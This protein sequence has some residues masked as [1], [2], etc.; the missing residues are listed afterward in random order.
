[1]EYLQG[2][3]EAAYNRPFDNENDEVEVRSIINTEF[4]NRIT[5]NL[6]YI[7]IARAKIIEY[8][9]KNDIILIN[10]AKR[11]LK[12]EDFVE[13]V[14][15]EVEL[16]GT[17]TF[18][19][20][21]EP[22]YSGSLKYYAKT[23]VLRVVNIFQDKSIAYYSYDHPTLRFLNLSANVEFIVDDNEIDESDD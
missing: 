6:D 19:N 23:E 1:M 11:D 16:T 5:S 13:I 14:Y 18:G 10:H 3:V 12:T 21:T 17:E 8:F 22:H 15:L 7:E 9:K 20:I 2:T 4:R